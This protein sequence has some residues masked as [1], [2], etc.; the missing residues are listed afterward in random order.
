M[1]W[2]TFLGQ[3]NL[4][5]M[6]QLINSV[7]RMF[8]VLFVSLQLSNAMVTTKLTETHITRD[9]ADLALNRASP[10]KL[11]CPLGIPLTPRHFKIRSDSEKY[12][13]RVNLNKLAIIDYELV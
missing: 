13:T 9:F 10:G 7:C 4:A 3:L 12:M 5:F 6:F 2:G 8:H 1:Y 11:F